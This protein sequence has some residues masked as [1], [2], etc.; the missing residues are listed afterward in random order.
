VVQRTLIRP[1]MSRVGPLKPD[2]RAALIAADTVMG[3]KYKEALDRVSAHER[4]QERS[5]TFGQVKEGF[6]KF[7]DLFKFGKGGGGGG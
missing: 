2:E 6:R 5:S 1:P 7:G 3:A 4:L